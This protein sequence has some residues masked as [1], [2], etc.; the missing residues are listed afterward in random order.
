MASQPLHKTAPKRSRIQTQNRAAI[1]QAA[2][3]VF[4]SDG[5]RGATLE[6]IAD[7]A[8]MSKTNLLYYFESKE[9]I[10]ASVIEQTVEGWLQPFKDIDAQGDPIEELRR[11]ITLKLKL[12]REAPEASRLFA[13]EIQRGAPLVM[14]F[15]E[16]RLKSL[17]D[18]KA[19]VLRS[20]IDAGRIAPVDPYHLI[21][22]IWAT[23]QH[24]ADFETQIDVLLPGQSKQTGAD[25]QVAHAVISIL[26]NGLKPRAK[27]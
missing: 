19:A 18:E 10:Y 23:T 1:S 12:A 17:V 13:N 3:D 25:E 6:R 14:P 9:D 7:R 24:Y 27:T 21:F 16:T 8:G 5:Y 2:L 15:L 22:V 11:Y 26:L 4:S 20:W